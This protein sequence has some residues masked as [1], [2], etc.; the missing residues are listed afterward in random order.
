MRRSSALSLLAAAALAAAAPAVAQE[1]WTGAAGSK[2]WNDGGN[3]E[4]GRPPVPTIALFALFD[5][6]AGA[7]FGF[8]GDAP[9]H[10]GRIQLSTNS[11]PVTLKAPGLV[12]GGSVNGEPE[13]GF[14]AE[15]VAKDAIIRNC[16]SNA[17]TLRGGATAGW[18]ATG[19][20]STTGA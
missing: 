8:G 15:A 11:G 10:F 12:V 18:K 14:I 13:V 7:A 16:S 20:T 1:V 4:S 5:D 9:L 2:S 19:S 17:L 6:P 3:W